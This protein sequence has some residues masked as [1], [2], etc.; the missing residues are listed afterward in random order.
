VRSHRE[1]IT[2][3]VY[4]DL[5]PKNVLIRADGHIVMLTDFDLSLESTSSPALEDAT[6]MDEK[7]NVTPPTCLPIPELQLLLLKRCGSAE[8]RRGRSSCGRVRGARRRPRRGRQLVGL[9][10]VSLLAHL[11]AHPVRQGDQQRHAPQHR[12]PTS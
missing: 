6:S 9:R 8:P 5:K 12:V 11:R 4:R 3:N 1:C 7:D 2:C 10:L